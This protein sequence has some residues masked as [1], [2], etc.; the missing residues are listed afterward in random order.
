MCCFYLPTQWVTPCLQWA[1]GEEMCHLSSRLAT[2]ATNLL[3]APADPKFRRLRLGNATVRRRLIEPPGAEPWLRAL[4]FAPRVEAEEDGNAA[5][6]PAA[7]AAAGS[8]DAPPPP[9]NVLRLE[10]DVDACVLHA[11]LDALSGSS[12]LVAP[13][14]AQPSGSGA[15]APPPPP[16]PPASTA[17]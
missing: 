1:A 15:A 6:Q 16:A 4:G 5:E 9:P 10:G 12:A 11:S 8:A 17:A 13:S 14:A 2:L 7:V 3:R